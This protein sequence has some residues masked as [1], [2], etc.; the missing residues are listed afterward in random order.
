MKPIHFLSAS[1]LFLVSVSFAQQ[2]IYYN[3]KR[4][5]VQGGEA[6]S[7]Y[8]IIENDKN[9][10]KT[11]EST[12]VAA[13]NQL[14]EVLTYS[15]SPSNRDGKYEF[16]R[17]GILIIASNYT[18]GK[19]NG[20]SKMFYPDGKLQRDEMY[21]NGEL[22]SAKCY[23]RDGNEIPYFQKETKPEYPGGVSA[24]Y[25]Y[26]GKNFSRKTKGTGKIIVQ[27]VIDQ[28]GSPVELKI[29]KGI[30]PILDEEAIRVVKSME[31]WKPGLQDGV[32]VRVLY[33]LPIAL[34]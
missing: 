34:N 21:Q 32:P 7:Y 10:G 19:L 2:K 25:A 11:T 27:F 30:D 28:K 8:K 31:K 15:G 3:N 14:T 22:T 13:N 9:S 18:D 12:Y 23:G 33:S 16:W 5:E 17:E 26:I 24:L 20:N 4:E 1:L 29:V 6:A